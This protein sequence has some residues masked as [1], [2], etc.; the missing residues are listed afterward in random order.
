M[1]GSE[2]G[3]EKGMGYPIKGDGGVSVRGKGWG[4]S[5]MGRK[6]GDREGLGRV[7]VFGEGK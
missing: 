3:G 2:M 4:E 5:T 1:S 7:N 6:R